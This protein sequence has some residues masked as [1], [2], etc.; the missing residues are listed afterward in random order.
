MEYIRRQDFV[1][2]GQDYG[3]GDGEELVVRED[4]VTLTGLD[5]V[6]RLEETAAKDQ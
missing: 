2:H 6:L 1:S 4:L 5:L 3:Q